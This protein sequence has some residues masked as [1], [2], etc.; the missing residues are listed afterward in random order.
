MLSEC[1]AKGRYKRYHSAG[2]AN[3]LLQMIGCF[4]KINVHAVFKDSS[5]YRSAKCNVPILAILYIP[6]IILYS[7]I[8]I[9]VCKTKRGGLWYH[10]VMC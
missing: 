1:I 7:I 10:S 4:S 8:Y 3:V 5:F 2:T 6:T 9:I